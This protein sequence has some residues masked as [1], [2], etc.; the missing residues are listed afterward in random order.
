MRIVV[1]PWLFF[2]LVGG[3]VFDTGGIAPGQLGGDTSADVA[4]VDQGIGGDERPDGPLPDGPL[5][6]GPLPD[7]PVTDAVFCLCNK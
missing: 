2:L 3:C 4:W 7:S 1:V 6:D 5:P